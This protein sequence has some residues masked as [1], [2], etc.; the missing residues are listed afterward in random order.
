MSVTIGISNVV[1]RA[2]NTYGI[3]KNILELMY[4]R[5]FLKLP[6][7]KPSSIPGPRNEPI[8]VRFALSKLDLKTSFTPE[9]WDRTCKSDSIIVAIYRSLPVRDLLYLPT[10]FKGML[11]GLNHI[12]SCHHEERFGRLTVRS[13]SAY[14][15][16]HIHIQAADLQLFVERA[17]FHGCLDFERTHFSFSLVRRSV[18]R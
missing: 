12:W 8:L 15:H 14:S 17:L 5:A 9:L 16:T 2:F 3:V 13:I 4:S 11:L 18:A 7:F 6:T 1:L 10:H